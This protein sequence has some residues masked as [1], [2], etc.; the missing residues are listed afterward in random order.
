MFTDVALGHV[1]AWLL[2]MSDEVAGALP[3]VQGSRAKPLSMPLASALAD[4][5]VVA[6][7]GRM[8]RA[9]VAFGCNGAR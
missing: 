4:S 9:T 8:S 6:C 3:G 1:L 5:L 7:R 2:P